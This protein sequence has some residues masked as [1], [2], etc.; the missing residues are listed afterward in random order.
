M[1][2]RAVAIVAL[3]LAASVAA[4]SQEAIATARFIRETPHDVVVELVRI[5]GK[6]E[7]VLARN[8]LLPDRVTTIDVV[9]SSDYW[10]RITSEERAPL[11]IAATDAL[12]GD[13]WHVPEV[14]PTRPTVIWATAGSIDRPAFGGAII[15]AD[16]AA[17]RDGEVFAVRY[18][19]FKSATSYNDLWTT[20]DLKRCRW[21]VAGIAGTHEATLRGARGF[22]GTRSFSPRP[23]E[24]ASVLVS[25][26]AVVVSGIVTINGTPPQ[27]A[28]LALTRPSATVRVPLRSDGSFEAALDQPGAYQLLLIIPNARMRP[29]SSTFSIGTNEVVWDINDKAANTRVTVRVSGHDPSLPTDIE[30]RQDDNLTL[31][32]IAAGSDTLE[33][34]GLSFGT[35][36]IIARQADATSDWQPFQLSAE[37][38]TATIGIALTRSTRT[39]ALRYPDG[40]PIMSAGFVS[41]TMVRP[42]EIAP[43]TYSLASIPE[44]TR[45]VI[46]PPSGAPLC[47]VVPPAGDVTAISSRGRSVTLRFEG[48]S[49]N[50]EEIEI[51]PEGSDCPVALDRFLKSPVRHDGDGTTQLDILNAPTDDVLMIHLR[52][53]LYRVI[54]PGDGSVVIP[55]K[56]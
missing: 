32:A 30:I 9:R 5:T 53:G 10:L 1:A 49:V 43:G 15:T 34:R 16:P 41:N 24:T 48:R 22:A 52:E 45:L 39:L 42:A 56:Q 23:R 46:R 4:R 44:G 26:P 7:T 40:E 8:S 11:L 20:S 13:I 35:H 47:K 19:S 50:T 31:D 38:P 18:P 28:H 25:P 17:C 27:D 36:R 3:L 29:T 55:A 37:Q 14:P 2:I 6:Q 12:S 21:V 51:A 54:V 33:Q